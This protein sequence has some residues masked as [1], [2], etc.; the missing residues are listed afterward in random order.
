MGRGQ[1]AG[2]VR[3]WGSLRYIEWYNLLFF[4][5]K[6]GEKRWCQKHGGRGGLVIGTN[7]WISFLYKSME[8][9]KKTLHTSSYPGGGAELQHIPH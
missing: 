8:G 2:A 3:I 4:L 9:E 5:D 1:K 6:E 7:S